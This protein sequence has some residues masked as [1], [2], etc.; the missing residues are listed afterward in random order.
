MATPPAAIASWN[1]TSRLE[2]VPP[3]ALPSL[4]ADLMKRL[5]S[6]S[7]PMRS[8]VKARLVRAAG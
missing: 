5:R 4:V 2:G 3:R 8:G 7:G 1:C 6:S